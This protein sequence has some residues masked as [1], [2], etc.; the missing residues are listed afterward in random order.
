MGNSFSA[1]SPRKA[2]GPG[3]QPR[4]AGRTSGRPHPGRRLRGTLGAARGEAWPGGA[5]RRESRAG[6]QRS[7]VVRVSASSPGAASEPWR[8]RRRRRRARPEESGLPGIGGGHRDPPE[9]RLPRSP[10]APRPQRPRPFSSLARIPSLRP[11]APWRWRWRRWR[12][13]SRPAA[14]GTS[15]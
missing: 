12:R 11:A 3:P 15:R 13:W 5:A 6:R 1:A 2:S 4:A 9:A 10:G 8:R 14:A 7:V